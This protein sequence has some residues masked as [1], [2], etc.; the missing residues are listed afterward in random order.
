M[1]VNKN[2]IVNQRTENFLKKAWPTVASAA[3]NHA[4]KILEKRVI[5]LIE[6]DGLYWYVL[7]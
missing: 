1:G 2:D 5:G 7:S 3:E 6:M 4:S